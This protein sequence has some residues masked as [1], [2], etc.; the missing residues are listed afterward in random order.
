MIPLLLLHGA[1]GSAA[2]F[3]NLL[4]LLPADWP[5]HALNFP[6]HGGAAVREPFSL[7]LFTGTVLNFLEEQGIGQANVFGYSMGGYVA[8]HLAATH[9]DRVRQVVTL[10]TKLDWSPEVAA[11]MG[12]MFDPEKILAK[13]PQFADQLAQLHGTAHWP[14]V[15]RSTA[16]FLQDLGVGQGLP[17]AAFARIS[18]PVTL[19]WGELDTMVTAAE[20]RRVAGEIALGKFQL[21]EGVKHALEQVDTTVLARYLL[22]AFR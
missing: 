20:S 2:Q 7:S 22:A 21:L 13:V 8:L 1:L 19:G 12:R 9:P 6:G 10:G 15:C 11:G 14:S 4:V 5:V 17:A 18:C 3:D 16:A